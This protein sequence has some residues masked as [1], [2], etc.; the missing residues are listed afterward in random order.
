MNASQR[1]VEP[2]LELPPASLPSIQQVPLLK[3]LKPSPSRWL[4]AGHCITPPDDLVRD[5]G[6]L[7]ITIFR[8]RAIDAA[9]AQA[10]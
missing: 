10:P 8:R 6:D 5:R 4:R 1:E 3:A 7:P 2:K 9:V